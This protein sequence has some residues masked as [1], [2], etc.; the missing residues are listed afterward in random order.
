MV[1]ALAK[2]LPVGVDGLLHPGHGTSLGSRLLIVLERMKQG[3]LGAQ[4]GK[5]RRQFGAL[6]RWHKGRGQARSLA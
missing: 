5:G 6:W 3:H 1:A 2:V 4:V